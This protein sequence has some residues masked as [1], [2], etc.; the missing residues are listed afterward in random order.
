MQHQYG[1]MALMNSI[2]YYTL[3]TAAS[4]GVQAIRAMQ[5]REL[6]VKSLQEFF[7]AQHK[8]EKAA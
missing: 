6:D 3:L 1:R 2:P 8:N 7:P 5:S 4:A